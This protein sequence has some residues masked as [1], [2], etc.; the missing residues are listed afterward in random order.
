MLQFICDYF[1]SYNSACKKFASKHVLYI[2]STLDT[3]C[4]SIDTIFRHISKS[5]IVNFIAEQI[6]YRLRQCDDRKNYQI[7]CCLLF[8]PLLTFMP[9]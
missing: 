8:W 6:I 5:N 1:I 7:A 3:T 9:K 2:N 4:F